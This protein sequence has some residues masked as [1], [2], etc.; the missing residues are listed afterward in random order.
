M[1]LNE[2]LH[3]NRSK[4]EQR[5]DEVVLQHD[6]AQNQIAKPFKAYSETPNFEVLPHAA[7]FLDIVPS[8]NYL[9]CSMAHGLTDQQLD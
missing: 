6:I 2:A 4:C 8:D 9:F 1:R 3:E 5:E 7:S